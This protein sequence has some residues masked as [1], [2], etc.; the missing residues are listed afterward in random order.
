MIKT[1]RIFISVIMCWSLFAGQI[2]AS[3]FSLVSKTYAQDIEKVN[4]TEHWQ[5]KKADGHGNAVVNAISLFL[6]GW[7]AGA[8]SKCRKIPPSGQVFI[9]GGIVYLIGEISTTFK[10]KRLIRH[11]ITVYK[12][13]RYI[14]ASQKQALIAQMKA[15]DKY[16]ATIK[17]R[18]GFIMGAFIAF[19]VAAGLSFAS[20]IRTGLAQGRMNG[21]HASCQAGAPGE[22]AAGGG[23]G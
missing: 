3:G 10:M 1:F 21:A 19:Q 14:D 12:N 4:A 17:Q 16:I 23:G 15:Y 9:I 22:M 20:G 13:S 11:E 7:L 8:M 18:M 5:E 6:A 2:T